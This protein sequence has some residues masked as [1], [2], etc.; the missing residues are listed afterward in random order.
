MSLTLIVFNVTAQVSFPDL[1]PKGSIRQKVGLTTISV[2]YERPA[3]RG[4]KVFGELVPYDK[5]WRT[6]A[7]NCTKIKFSDNVLIEN[8]VI[9]AG[10]YSLFTIP[11]LQEW[12]IILNS[13]TTLYGTGGYNELKDIVRFRAKAKATERYYESFT[14]DIDVIPNNAEVNISWEKTNITFEVKTETD[15]K[16]A[17]MVNEQ[18]L[19]GKI[20]DPQLLAMGAE[21]F[22][23][24]GRD[25]ETGLA[26]VNQ[27]IDIKTSSWYYALKVDILTKSKRYSEAIETLKLNIAY[28][29]TNPENWTKEQLETVLEG[30]EMQMKELR[31]KIE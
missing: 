20:K 26:L 25:L 15:K 28:V 14:I 1:S 16:I 31:S 29:K 7:G 6:G 8:K 13:D 23:F 22:Y 4:R 5:L 11:D 10:T 19:S 21:Y 30:Q 9:L 24:L 27:A 2:I 12:T 17:K 3:A 18:L